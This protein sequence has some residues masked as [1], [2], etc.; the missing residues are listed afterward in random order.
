MGN[1]VPMFPNWNVSAKVI[2]V[3]TKKKRESQNHI[4]SIVNHATLVREALLTMSNKCEGD[5][6]SLFS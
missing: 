2:A 4:E 1:T 3:L 5:K 6:I